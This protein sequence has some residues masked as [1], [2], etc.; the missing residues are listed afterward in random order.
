MSKED[1]IASIVEELTIE[2][3]KEVGFDAAILELKVRNAY[4][5]V[6]QV[7]NYPSY[8]KPE[9]KDSDMENYFSNIKAIALYDYSKI[10][11]EGQDSY[12]AD[13]ESIKPW[14]HLLSEYT[15]PAVPKRYRSAGT[16]SCLPRKRYSVLPGRASDG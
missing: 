15:C 13:G 9:I 16:A 8:Y 1:I 12:S 6:Q 3:T 2:L 7:R 10:G 11:A 14:S 4:R 5:E